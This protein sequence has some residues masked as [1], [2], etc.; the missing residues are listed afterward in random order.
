[1]HYQGLDPNQVA[2]LLHSLAMYL[3]DNGDVIEP[4]HTIP[5][6]A[7]DSAWE[8]TFEEALVDPKREVLDLNPGPVHAGGD[9]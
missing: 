3:L 1:M 6:T 4:G 9:R 2:H 7:P 8:C 5:G